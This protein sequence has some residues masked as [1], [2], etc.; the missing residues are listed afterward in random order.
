ML[1]TSFVIYCDEIGMIIKK[2]GLWIYVLA[3]T[4]QMLFFPIQE[5]NLKPW[6]L[7]EFFQSLKE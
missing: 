1:T 2:Q 7:W 3:I 5:E 4:N 6:E